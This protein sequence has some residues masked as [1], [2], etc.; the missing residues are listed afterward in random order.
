MNGEYQG[1]D[2]TCEGDD[3]DDGVDGTCGDECPTDPDKVTPG[4]CGCGEGDADS[5]GDG[6]L[7]CIDNC[8]EIGNPGQEDR[9]GDGIGDVCDNCPEDAN[10]GQGDID[11]N[12]IGDA[13]EEPGQ[14]CCTTFFGGVCANASPSV[15]AGVG[16]TPQGSGTSCLSGCLPGDDPVQ[17]CCLPDGSC[18]EDDPICCADRGGAPSGPTVCPGD[19]PP[20]SGDQNDDGVDDACEPTI[21]T[22]S[23]WGLVVLALL[24]L[25]SAKICFA[26]RRV[27]PG[28]T[29]TTS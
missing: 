28:V 1:D 26:R 10:P 14:A 29:P 16:G 13:C 17:A 8:P 6:A 25:V 23:E 22:V 7:D 11:G 2:T 15:C 3:D 5:D 24:L 4:I 12:G 21:P 18:V 19:S 9:D 20:C 27:R